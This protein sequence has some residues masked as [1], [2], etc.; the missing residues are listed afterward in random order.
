M[1]RNKFDIDENLESPFDINH[2]KR[3][4]IYIRKQKIP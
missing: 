3:A 2:F 1:A 4:M